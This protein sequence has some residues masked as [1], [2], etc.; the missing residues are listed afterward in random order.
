[1]KTKFNILTLLIFILI[2]FSFQAMAY[3][4]MIKDNKIT[5]HA[6]QVKL[7]TLMTDLSQKADIKV[8]IDSDLNPDISADFKNTDLQT[9][10]QSIL[11]P[12]NHVFEWE[13]T[14]AF[15]GSIRL[16]K[17]HIFKDDPKNL[18]QLAED[19]S[20]LD[21]AR[22]PADNSFFV[23]G[24]LLIRLKPGRELLYLNQILKQMGG[25]LIQEK[26]SL[27]IYRIKLPD[28]TNI[29][30]LVNQIKDLPGI[31]VAEP[32]YAYPI[33]QPYRYVTDTSIDTKQNLTTPLDN[34]MPIAVL[35]SG[36]ALGNMP[37]GHVLATQDALNPATPISDPLGH[38]TQMALVAA[39]IVSPFG[40]KTDKESSNPIIA[41]RAFDKNG[42]TSSIALM[43][44]IDFALANNAKVVS[45]SWGSTTPSKFINDTLEYAAAKGLIIVASAGNEPT[46][47][48][49]Y[50]AA[51]PSVIGIGALA[52]DGKNW[53]NTNYGY[54]VEGFLPG[55]AD[56]PVGYKADPGIY[57]GTS[58]SAA[59]A[60]NKIAAFLSKNPKATRKEIVDM[61]FIQ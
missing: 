32:N 20:F 7:Q 59:F 13:S 39:G 16:A 44:S 51:Y 18:T 57:A 46:G 48:P 31:D 56:M 9:A 24:E 14:P 22:N 49:V 58:I 11:N 43:R 60:A 4:L 47:N 54:F 38:G 33:I 19:D 40:S 3:E 41:I 61:L 15:S 36:L 17:I 27:G 23:K 29:P 21:I 8:L 30:E 2:F 42:F 55:F 26:N 5:V 34:S 28:Q 52:P 35:D 6:D 50:P 45:L 53:E 25:T 10:L 1:M 37:D 12:F